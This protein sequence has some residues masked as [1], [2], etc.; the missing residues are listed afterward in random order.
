MNKILPTFCFLLLSM[1]GL[2]A[3]ETY[4]YHIYKHIDNMGV[5]ESRKEYVYITFKGD[6]LWVS[7][8]DGSYKI[9]YDGKR[10][11]TIY[12]YLGEKV[13]TCFYY[14]MFE[15]RLMNNESG[16]KEADDFGKYLGNSLYRMFYFLVTEDKSLINKV[17]RFDNG[18]T[19]T[20]CY[21][22]CPAQNCEKPIKPNT[23]PIIR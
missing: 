17:T 21:E 6:L 12:K 16:I 23:Q 15:P 5:P 7:E 9:G 11:K 20:D 2:K 13:D 10:D 14:G 8:K 1:A 22:L 18:D 4:C 19:F 3:Q